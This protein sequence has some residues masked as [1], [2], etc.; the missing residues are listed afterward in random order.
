MYQNLL[1]E[2]IDHGSKLYDEITIIMQSEQ[3]YSVDSNGKKIEVIKENNSVDFF[4]R[5]L[6]N[7]AELIFQCKKDSLLTFI[8]EKVDFFSEADNKIIPFKTSDHKVS[9]STGKYLMD[10][11][12]N[13]AQYFN[14]FHDKISQYKQIIPETIS[15]SYIKSNQ[16]LLNNY[17][18]ES[19][20][21]SE[22]TSC[23][24]GLSAKEQQERTESDGF[25]YLNDD[26]NINNCLEEVIY[27]TIKHLGIQP[28][29]TGTYDIVLKNNISANIIAMV[30]KTIYGQTIINGQSCLHNK[31]NHKIFANNFNIIEKPHMGIFTSIYDDEAY[32][33][34]DSPI[35]TNGVLNRFILN[36]INATKLNS[37]ST[38]NSYNFKENISCLYMDGNEQYDDND[39]VL[40]DSLLSPNYNSNTGLF[41]ASISGIYKGKPFDNTVL[42][43]NI[44]DIFSD[45]TCFNDHYQ[46]GNLLIP[47]LKIR[48]DL[49]SN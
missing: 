11:E 49:A 35:I 40:V 22:S 5:C 23:Y 19:I 4:V 45:I 29:K 34:S 18:F 24:I 12:K 36:N 6:K 25:Y 37:Q 30:L 16:L 14:N 46:E 10:R 21:F 8:Q 1:H 3:E 39:C 7:N 33:L 32:Q 9:H 13:F 27:N 42:H 48:A 15:F 43:G 20:N 2:A 47:S 41:S 44:F 28:I 17:G 26:T 31:L 38:H